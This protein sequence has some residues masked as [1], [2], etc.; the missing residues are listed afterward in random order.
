MKLSSEM[1][2]FRDDLVELM[3]GETV[4]CEAYPIKFFPCLFCEC[5]QYNLVKDNPIDPEDHSYR[6]EH[7]DKIKT[8]YVAVSPKVFDTLPKPAVVAKNR[9]GGT[10]GFGSL[11]RDFATGRVFVLGGR[12]DDSG[13]YTAQ[14]VEEDSGFAGYI[15]RLDGGTNE[16]TLKSEFEAD[17][18]VSVDGDW[19]Y[20]DSDID[21]TFGG[22][23]IAE[24]DGQT[25]RQALELGGLA[26]GN[27]LFAFRIPIGDDD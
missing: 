8:D 17:A 23:A 19:Y 20:F 26:R 15:N 11:I 7:V 27:A 6:C 4:D 25:T 9:G 24:T 22:R 3:K 13:R 1:R 16:V 18:E 10:L 2:T 12:G 14:N 5:T 21:A